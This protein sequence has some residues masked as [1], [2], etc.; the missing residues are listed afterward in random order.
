MAVIVMKVVK[1]ES[2]PNAD[3]LRV[4]SFENQVGEAI[5]VVAN[6]ENIYEVGDHAA[7]ASVGTLFSDG[8]LIRETKL[9]GVESYGMAMGKVSEVVGTNLDERFGT[10]TETV[11]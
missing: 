9:R 4:Y 11:E 7:V 10:K 2:H 3:R 5:Q 1:A 6:L 8:M